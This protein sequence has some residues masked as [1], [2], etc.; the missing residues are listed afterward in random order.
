MQ[1]KIFKTK[2]GDKELIVQLDGLAEQASG[3]ALVRYGDTSV[4][5]TAQLGEERPEMGF[6]PLTC[7]YVERYY[8]AGKIL[9]SRFIRREGRP[10][11]EAVLAS[12]MIDRAIRPLFPKEIANEIQVIATCL[13]WDGENDPAVLGLLGASLAL[14]LSQIPWPGPVGV[15]RVG[16]VGEK[17]ILNPNYEEREEGD[18]DLVFAGIESSAKSGRAGEQ[19]DI[20]VNMIEAGAEEVSE[21]VI[22]KAYDF[23]KLYIRETIDL[24]KEIIKKHGKEKT[25]VPEPVKLEPALEKKIRKALAKDLEKAFYQKDKLER[26]RAWLGL[27][28]KIL[29][30]FRE[31][32]GEAGASR[33]RTI[34][35][36]ETEKMVKENI[37]EKEKRPDGRKLD[38]FREIGC[39]VGIVPRTHGSG[40]FVRGLTRVLSI[41]TL[42]APGDQQLLEG[43]EISGKKRFLHHY[44]FPP[45]CSGEV[46][47]LGSPK[48]REI[49]HGM[50][51]EKALLPLIPSIEDFPYTIRVVSEV[52]SSNGSTSM[53]AV[54]A[55]SLA[56]MDAGVPLTRPAAGIAVGLITDDSGKKIKFLTD[57]QGPEDHH[58]EMDFKVAGT[59]KGIT[60]MQMDVKSLGI[61]REI[62]KGGLEK[63]K[64]ARM[65][66]LSEM[67][68]KIS[69]PRKELSVFA[70]RVYTLQINPEKIGAVIGTGGKVINE[71]IDECG[72]SIDI[73]DSGK[74]FVTAEKAEAAQ[75]AVAWIKNLA[76]EFKVGEVFQAKVT[77]ILDFGAMVEVAPGQEGLVHIS[78]FAPFR[79]EKIQDVVKVGDIIPVKIINID[80]QGRINLSAKDA[81]F[82]PK[83][84]NKAAKPGGAS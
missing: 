29:E 67:K 73:E 74:V 62:L 70:P 68:K 69:K 21:E 71:I 24:Q 65:S 5:A 6:F 48:R 19:G 41:L 81:G 76:R 30:D 51:A 75:K 58:G 4:L 66:I 27:E 72:V 16:R 8:A 39:D 40:V 64:K 2:I 10:T 60:V 36:E 63:A 61:T 32:I 1:N 46:K 59:E 31:E 38:E 83:M 44:N 55:A 20:F 22:V 23:A 13:S 78:Q 14:G 34:F 17:L 77:R 33:V 7:E 54:S 26:H 53:G 49:G 35:L 3:C 80:V 57:I 15:V 28:D 50:L 45:Y 43:M 12:R 47:R 37:L 42:G 18:L 79:I 25:S 9:G 56:L 82:K 11:T 52:L 84:K